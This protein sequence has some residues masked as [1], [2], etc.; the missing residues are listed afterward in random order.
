MTSWGSGTYGGR[1]QTTDF[2][3]HEQNDNLQCQ[4]WQHCVCHYPSPQ[5]IY[6][7]HHIPKPHAE[8]AIRWGNATIVMVQQLSRTA[9]VYQSYR[10]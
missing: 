7:C 8:Y 5:F 2:I 4:L 10:L 3:Q 1:G 6:H 9:R